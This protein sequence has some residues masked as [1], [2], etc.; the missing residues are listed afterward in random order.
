[1]ELVILHQIVMGLRVEV[2][3]ISHSLKYSSMK[4]VSEVEIWARVVLIPSVNKSSDAG[5]SQR[6]PSVVGGAHHCRSQRRFS[7]LRK[8]G[9][10]HDRGA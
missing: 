5:G 9:R 7:G 3:L 4:T 1:M 6:V 10:E 8:C 2:C